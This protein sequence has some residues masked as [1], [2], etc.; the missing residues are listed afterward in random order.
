MTEHSPEWRFETSRHLLERLNRLYSTLSGI[1]RAIVRAECPSDIYNAAC[2][3]VVEEG[4]LRFAIIALLDPQTRKLVAI[5]SAGATLDLQ[6]LPLCSCKGVTIGAGC[7]AWIGQ[8][9]P[10]I[11]NDIHTGQCAPRSR[12][13][14]E[15]SGIQ[16]IAS[17]PLL[18][19]KATIGILVVGAGEVDY[20]GKAERHLLEEVAEDVSFAMDVLRRDERLLADEAKMHYLA[21]Y[22]TRTGLPGRSLFE[23]RLAAICEQDTSTTI[24]VMVINLRNYHEILQALGL[25]ASIAIARTI[26][27]RIETLLP[28]TLIARLGE[29]VFA[30]AQERQKGEYGIEETAWRIYRSIAE[31]IVVDEQEVFLDAFIG[32]ATF[33]KDGG[34]KEVVKAALAVT[35]KVPLIRGSCCRFFDSGMDSKSRKHLDLDAALHRAIARREFELY[36]QP[37]VDLSNGRMV[38][39]EALLR[40]QNPNNGLVPPGKFIA[41]LEETGLICAV[42]EWVMF[43][44]CAARRRWQDDGLPPVRVA[45]NLSGR[46]F[47]DA[48]INTLVRRAL[49]E[50]RLDP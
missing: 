12:S 30:L 34:A 9:K 23:E 10:C 46:Q 17:F 38:G 27:T 3:I 24:A 48:D 5:A 43:E 22:D 41:T 15:D 37:Q 31:G 6:W 40:W 4:N 18:L 36:Y 20:F 25:N 7:D 35:D 32:I 44:A 39:V 33:P 49:H 28:T 19:D 13:M 26:T 50:A 45:V 47:R 11:L 14:L 16:A 2:R 1:N 8:G 21:Y 29:A 42:G